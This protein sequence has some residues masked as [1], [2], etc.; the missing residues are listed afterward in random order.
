MI[1]G[2]IFQVR[3]RK[4]TVIILGM[5]RQISATAVFTPAKCTLSIKHALHE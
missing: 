1:L 2:K 5:Y 4:L 3:Q